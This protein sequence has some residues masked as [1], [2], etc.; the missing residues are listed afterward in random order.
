MARRRIIYR[1]KPIAQPMKIPNDLL[2][3]GYLVMITD[4]SCKNISQSETFGNSRRV[5]FRKADANE[6][7]VW[8][9]SSCDQVQILPT[10]SIVEL[11]GLD[12]ENEDKNYENNNCD[13]DTT[14]VNRIR[15]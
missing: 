4:C 2:E 7:T 1:G 3:L 13:L 8:E 12:I 11:M 14:L 15:D 6:G 5:F 9:C 10:Q